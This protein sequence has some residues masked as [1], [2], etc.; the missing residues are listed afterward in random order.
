MHTREIQTAIPEVSPKLMTQA[1][2]IPVTSARWGDRSC[3]TDAIS[4]LLN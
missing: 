2:P 1:L 4:S 3:I